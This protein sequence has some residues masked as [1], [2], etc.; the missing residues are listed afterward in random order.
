MKW[1]FYFKD[2]R[3][4]EGDLVNVVVRDIFTD[5]EFKYK[6][7]LRFSVVMSKLAVDCSKEFESEVHEFDMSD[8]VSMSKIEK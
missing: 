6:G 5:K 3:F 1:L 2:E 8:I 4:E 7:K